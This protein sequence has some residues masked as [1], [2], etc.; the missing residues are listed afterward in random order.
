MKIIEASCYDRDR[1]NKARMKTLFRIGI[2]LLTL[3][4]GYLIFALIPPA[5]LRPLFPYKDL[6]G[7]HPALD[8]EI[9][10][11]LQHH[12][13]IAVV[14]YSFVGLLLLLNTV[15]ISVLWKKVTVTNTKG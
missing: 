15:A 7:T 12:P 3:V 6:G 14:Y 8:W 1:N 13:S 9:E 11:T 10:Q 2:G 5:W 4:E